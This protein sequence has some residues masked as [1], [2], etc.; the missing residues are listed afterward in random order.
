MTGVDRQVLSS[1]SPIA[2][3]WFDVEEVLAGAGQRQVPRVATNL[4]P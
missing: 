3:E 2:R 1:E 4:S